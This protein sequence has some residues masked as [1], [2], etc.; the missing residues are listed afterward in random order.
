MVKL[1]FH[2]SVCQINFNLLTNLKSFCINQSKCPEE[3]SYKSVLNYKTC[4]NNVLELKLVHLIL[5]Q[6]SLLHRK[7]HLETQ[8]TIL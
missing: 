3:L 1:N 8:S 7:V 5:G 2:L 4:K 6:Q